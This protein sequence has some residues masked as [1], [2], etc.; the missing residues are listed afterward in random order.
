MNKSVEPVEVEGSNIV[1]GN[2]DE[3]EPRQLN[4]TIA[5]SVD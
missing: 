1:R 3:E 5:A 4:K 2:A